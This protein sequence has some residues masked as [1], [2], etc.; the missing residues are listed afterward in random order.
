MV[1]F[2]EKYNSCEVN[3]QIIAILFI[4]YYKYNYNSSVI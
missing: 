1:H 3:L 4:N 2:Y